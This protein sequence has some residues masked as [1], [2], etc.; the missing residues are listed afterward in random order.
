MIPNF[1]CF[2]INCAAGKRC[3]MILQVL[4]GFDSNMNRVPLQIHYVRIFLTELNSTNYWLSMF[5]DRTLMRTEEVKQNFSQIT[6]F[7]RHLL[8]MSHFQLHWRDFRSLD[9]IFQQIHNSVKIVVSS[10][11]CSLEKNWAFWLRADL[12]LCVV[13]YTYINSFMFLERKNYLI[14]IFNNNILFGIIFYF[15]SEITTNE[16]ISN[17]VK[18]LRLTHSHIH[19]RRQ[20][21]QAPKQRARNLTE[22]RLPGLF[23]FC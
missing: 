16:N 12:C 13:V 17:A 7:K 23:F 14:N 5:L 9:L 4:L 21:I 6:L 20:T 10:P 8:K 3:E 11:E 15:S 1:L 19:K 22:V 2:W 18:I